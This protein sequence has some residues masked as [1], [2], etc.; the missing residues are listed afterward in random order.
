[1][2]G[3]QPAADA[4]YLVDI[5]DAI[6]ID[7]HGRSLFGAGIV[8]G[9]V[10]ALLAGQNPVD[11]G[12]GTQI[13]PD[14]AVART[15]EAFMAQPAQDRAGF[16]AGTQRVFRGILHD[17]VAIL[18]QC[19]SVSRFGCIYFLTDRKNSFQTN[20]TFSKRY[21]ITRGNAY[22]ETVSSAAQRQRGQGL[23]S[24]MRR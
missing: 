7:F 5:N 21:F 4:G 20:R 6:F 9:M 18:L 24:S 2:P 22:M 15:G 19:P 16:T 14:A 11:H 23:F 13:D 3:A 17:M 10:T 1:M 12:T 8:A